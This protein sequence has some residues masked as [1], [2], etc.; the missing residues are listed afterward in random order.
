[1]YIYTH[2]HNTHTHNHTY[3]HIIHRY[4][5]LIAY[6]ILSGDMLTSPALRNGDF[7]GFNFLTGTVGFFLNAVAMMHVRYTSALTHMIVG[8]VKGAVTT[9]I[10][11]AVLGDTKP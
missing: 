3:T 11:V 8:S 1:V 9:L 7:W 4:L 2:K 5:P 6:E 10:S